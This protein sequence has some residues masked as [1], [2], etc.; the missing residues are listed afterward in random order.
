MSAYIVSEDHID[1]LVTAAIELGTNG[2]Y[3]LYWQDQ[4]VTRNNAT[5]FGAMLLRE[6]IASVQRRYSDTEYADLPGPLVTP[7]VSEY[8]YRRFSASPF[9]GHDLDTIVQVL[10]AVSCYEYQSCEH[11]GWEMSDAKRACDQIRSGYIYRLPGY[12][13]AEWEVY[14]PDHDLAAD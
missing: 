13:D 5:A 8:T 11:A 10:K 4:R 6:N 2:G 9:S 3:G 1:Y 14:R 7:F 12:E